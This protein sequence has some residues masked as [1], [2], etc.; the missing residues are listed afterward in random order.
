VRW[1]DP[2]RSS[3]AGDEHGA[4]RVGRT[5]IRSDSPDLVTLLEQDA[6]TYR[7][8]RSASLTPMPE[9]EELDALAL[10]ALADVD[11]AVRRLEH[12]VS[13][14]EAMSTPSLKPADRPSGD[15]P[16]G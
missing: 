6:G 8:P 10:L 13:P 9:G 14:L 3:E 1:P 2:R 16:L 4:C 7:L 11:K 5:P 12:V 15:L